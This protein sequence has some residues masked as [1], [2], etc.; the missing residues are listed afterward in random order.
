[1]STKQTKVPWAKHKQNNISR[2]QIIRKVTRVQ[3]KQK[4][5]WFIRAQIYSSSRQVKLFESNTS[6]VTRSPR[7]SSLPHNNQAM[8]PWSE[9]QCELQDWIC[10]LS[11]LMCSSHIQFCNDRIAAY[12]L[13]YTSVSLLS[14]G[15]LWREFGNEDLVSADVTM[16]LRWVREAMV[17]INGCTRRY[18]VGICVV[19]LFVCVCVCLC[20]RFFVHV[21]VYLCM[22][23][24]DFG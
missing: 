3:H 18:S 8:N 22:Y 9:L 11:W 5:L 19:C 10:K 15:R 23:V 1:M 21:C 6:K 7:C 14:I 13:V 4:Y 2:G 16:Y 20:L 17:L 12:C 24:C